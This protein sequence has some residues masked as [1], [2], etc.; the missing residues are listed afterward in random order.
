MLEC[1]KDQDIDLQE[2]MSRIGKTR[3]HFETFRISNAMITELKANTFGVVTF[4]EIVI[5]DCI[6]LETIDEL[7]FK[8]TDRVTKTL[9]IRDNPKLSSPNNSIYRVLNKFVNIETI[10]LTSNN[11]NEIPDHAFS[12]ELTKLRR[13]TFSSIRFNKLG[14]FAFAKLPSLEFLNFGYVEFDHIPVQAFIFEE[15]LRRKLTITF[16]N[17]QTMTQDGRSIFKY[18][19]LANINRTTDIIFHG[20]QSL[21]TLDWIDIGNFL[22]NNEK[23]TID[24][25]D[26]YLDCDCCSKIIEFR[27]ATVMNRVKNFKCLVLYENKYLR[28]NKDNDQFRKCV[29]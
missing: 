20:H 18:G 26:S 25:G 8:G 19:S 9:I 16:K 14:K 5:E 10:Y 15:V 2:V 11:I 29:V 13:L 3:K 4:D 6:R 23:N 12:G 7:A 28:I 17:I 1:T 21:L 24:I 27:L 22:K